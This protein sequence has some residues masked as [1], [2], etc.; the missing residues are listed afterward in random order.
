MR[1]D[2]MLDGFW[3]N[4]GMFVGII[5]LSIAGACSIAG[6][7]DISETISKSRKKYEA[8]MVEVNKDDSWRREDIAELKAD[9]HRYKRKQLFFTFLMIFII[10]FWLFGIVLFITIAN[11]LK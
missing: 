1:S 3:T 5:M 4:F 11:N 8:L 2:N 10:S 6:M 9:A 7:H